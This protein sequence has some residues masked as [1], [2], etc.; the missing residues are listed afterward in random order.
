MVDHIYSVDIEDSGVDRELVL[1]V[2]LS[3]G[4]AHKYAGGGEVEDVYL[5][6]WSERYSVPRCQT[7]VYRHCLGG[8][9]TKISSEIRDKFPG[10]TDANSKNCEAEGE[11]LKRRTNALTAR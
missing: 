10:N 2:Y 8:L 3:S 7:P 9:V 6:Y 1:A 11:Q 4:S 5:S